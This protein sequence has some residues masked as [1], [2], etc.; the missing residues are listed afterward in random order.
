MESVGLLDRAGRRR[1]QATLSGF[2]HRTIRSCL[3]ERT[4]KS[5]AVPCG[6]PLRPVARPAWQ[7]KGSAADHRIRVQR[8]PDAWSDWRLI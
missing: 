1:S 5:R 6:R 7:G 3:A 8:P 2:H 4:T